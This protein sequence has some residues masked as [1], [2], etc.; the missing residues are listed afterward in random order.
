[1]TEWHSGPPPSVGWW[2]TS[3][4]GGVVILLRWW[5][6]AIWGLGL[7]PRTTAE[8]AGALALHKTFSPQTYIQWRERPESWPE[9]SKT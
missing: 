9:R 8:I 2:P 6:G 5:D 1:M 4:S 3:A 7:S